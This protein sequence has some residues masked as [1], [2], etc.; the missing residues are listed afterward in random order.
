M[1]V[2]GCGCIECACVGVAANFRCFCLVTWQKVFASQGLPKMA[3]T[4]ALC[5]KLAAATCNLLRATCYTQRRSVHCQLLLQQF[6]HT[7]IS[8]LY[9]YICSFFCPVSTS[10]SLFFEPLFDSQ[11]VAVAVATL[12]CGIAFVQYSPG[13]LR[14]KA[15]GNQLA[16]NY[17]T[18]TSTSWAF[19]LFWPS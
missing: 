17:R 9:T 4:L 8:T 11:K 10:S 14:P 1:R 12:K 18:C 19:G 5:P 2:C 15:F 3:K 6:F 13:G 16:T 7:P